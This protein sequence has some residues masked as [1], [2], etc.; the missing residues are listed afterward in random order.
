MTVQLS[1][2]VIATHPEILMPLEHSRMLQ[3][4]AYKRQGL[5]VLSLLQDTSTKR[6]RSGYSLLVQTMASKD[7]YRTFQDL[8]RQPPISRAILSQTFSLQTLRSLDEMSLAP[9]DGGRN[10]DV[11]HQVAQRYSV[12]RQ[13]ASFLVRIHHI[14]SWIASSE[15]H[16][17]HRENSATTDHYSTHLTSLDYGPTIACTV[18]GQKTNIQTESFAE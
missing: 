16:I 14:D 18:C 4:L 12:I 17:C 15:C 1:G 11:R 5:E 6:S 13:L 8:L 9:E 7:N 2:M 3:Q 10:D